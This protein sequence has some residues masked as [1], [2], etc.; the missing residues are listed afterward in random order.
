ML[1]RRHLGSAQIA[2]SNAFLV[3]NLV[4]EITNLEQQFGRLVREPYPRSSLLTIVCASS[5]KLVGGHEEGDQP[6]V[7]MPISPLRLLKSV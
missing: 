4:M 3:R 7:V 1:M 2:A 6:L 5:V